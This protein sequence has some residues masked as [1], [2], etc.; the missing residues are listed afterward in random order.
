MLSD[1]IEIIHLLLQ[2]GADPA[3]GDAAGRTPK[4]WARNEK[5]A[6]ALLAKGSL[7]G[8]R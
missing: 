5:I 6:K 7:E 2:R 8:Q 4:D 3:V 1:Q